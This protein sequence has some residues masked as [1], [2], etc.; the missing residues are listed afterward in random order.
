MFYQFLSIDSELIN[1]EYCFIDMFCRPR[2]VR[3]RAREDNTYGC[4]PLSSQI[5]PPTAPG[6]ITNTDTMVAN[7]QALSATV[8]VAV[9]QA[10]Q[11]ALEQ[12]PQALQLTEKPKGLN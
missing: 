5:L 1:I 11:K 3:K 9:S 4:D 12:V 8:S 6:S 7:V 2:N 10:V